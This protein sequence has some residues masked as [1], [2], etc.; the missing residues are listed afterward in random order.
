MAIFLVL[1]EIVELKIFSKDVTLFSFSATIWLRPPNCFLKRR[2]KM[3]NIKWFSILCSTLVIGLIAGCGTNSVP[4]GSAEGTKTETPEEYEIAAKFHPTIETKSVNNSMIIKY[5][6]KNLSDKSQ[7]LTFPSGLE[8]DYIVYDIHGK[9]IKQYSDEVM[10][11]QAIK[12]LALGSNQEIAKKFTISDLPNGRYQIEVFLTAKEEEAKVV[13]DLIVNNSFS[14]GSGVLVGQIDPNSIEIDIKGKKV[15][16]QLTEEAIKQLS[17]LN[18]GKQVSFLYTENET[19]Q[20]LIHKF[21]TG[22]P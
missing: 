11:T 22:T 21:V 9:K 8:A 12:I 17:Q 13:T 18:E 2:G 19:G 3:R 15:A 16:F 6:V 10:S 4:K 1:M 7:K 14:K 5:K 20:K